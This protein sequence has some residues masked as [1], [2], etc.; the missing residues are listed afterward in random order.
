MAAKDGQSAT[1]RGAS[2]P[3]EGEPKLYRELDRKGRWIR[4]ATTAFTIFHVFAM[5]VGGGTHEI[6]RP[7]VWV[8]GFYD[9]GMRMTNSWGMFG[10]PPG[11]THVT[12][13]GEK[14]DGTWVLLSTTSPKGKP[15][16]RRLRDVRI[17]KLQGKLADIVDRQR[18][19]LGY[20]DFFCRESK[21]Q[22]VELRSVRAVNYVHE[23]KNDQG[24][25]KRQPSVSILMTRTCAV[26]LATERNLLPQQNVSNNLDDGAL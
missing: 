25:V 14:M 8:V 21:E 15:L 7:F 17:R 9:Q 18:W 20:L 23:L 2:V 19:G 26:P 1:Q 10:K 6:K 12:V 24:A 4:G 3:A 16:L 13:E 11:A 5:I 22:G